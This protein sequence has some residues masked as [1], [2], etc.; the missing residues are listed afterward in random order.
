MLR[1]IAEC[2]RGRLRATAGIVRLEDQLIQACE[3]TVFLRPSAGGFSAWDVDRLLDVTQS[4]PRR[5]VALSDI[6]ELNEPWFISDEVRPGMT[7][8]EHVR[9]IVAADLSF[10]DHPGVQTVAYMD[11]M[12]RVARR[13]S[14]AGSDIEAVQ[15][16]ADPPPDHVD[17][18]PGDLPYDE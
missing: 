14:L 18:R 7:L 1:V 4:L 16:A 8:I 13:R 17:V 9:L 5:R 6:S 15:F 10:S 11:G 12:H 3:N 2:T